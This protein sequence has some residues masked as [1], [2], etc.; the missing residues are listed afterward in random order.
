VPPGGALQEERA[1]SDEFSVGAT[2]PRP[3]DRRRRHAEDRAAPAS[4]ELGVASARLPHA[5]ERVRQGST[6]RPIPV[7][8]RRVRSKHHAM[9]VKHLYFDRAHPSVVETRRAHR[10]ERVALE[11]DHSSLRS[12][13]V[14]SVKPWRRLGANDCCFERFDAGTSPPNRAVRQN[15]RLFRRTDSLF[16]R[17]A[18]DPTGTRE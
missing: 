1:W 8:E 2:R 6:H 5:R 13:R 18:L 11:S 9:P 14:H 3:A 7:D 12:K 16:V 15:G 10:K 4:V 17:T